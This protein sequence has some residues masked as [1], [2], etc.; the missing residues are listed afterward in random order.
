MCGMFGSLRNGLGS[1]EASGSSMN[2][3]FD[4]G[5]VLAGVAVVVT[6]MQARN[7]L[8]SATAISLATVRPPCSLGVRC[9]PS[10]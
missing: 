2:N 6:L 1:G 4:R 10:Q 8:P 9:R 3:V 5:Q 7:V